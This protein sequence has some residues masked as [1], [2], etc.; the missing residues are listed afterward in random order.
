MQSRPIGGD[1]LTPPAL[2]VGHHSPRSKALD[3]GPGIWYFAPCFMM[4]ES[5]PLLRSLKGRAH[6]PT[7]TSLWNFLG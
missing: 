1:F 7:E 2:G 6:A 5:P 3:S 4:G